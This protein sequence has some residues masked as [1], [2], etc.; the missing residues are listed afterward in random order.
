[1]RNIFLFFSILSFVYILSC[2]DVKKSQSNDSEMTLLMR[3]MYDEG[4][5][6]KKQILKGEKP[7]VSIRVQ[8]M[9]TA[10]ST[11]P[12]VAKSEMF[13]IFA[14]SYLAATEALASAEPENVETAYGIMVMSCMNCHKQLCPG[15]MVKIQKLYLQNKS[16]E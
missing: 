14:K 6:I 16:L 2:S 5:K 3:E 9:R 10:K 12:E 13:N 8:E 1:M 4:M 15:P 7:E 11:D